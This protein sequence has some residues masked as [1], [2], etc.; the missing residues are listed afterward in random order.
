MIL[1][2]CLLKVLLRFG[3]ARRFTEDLSFAGA[4]DRKDFG[5]LGASRWPDNGDPRSTTRTR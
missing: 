1:P 2:P 3:K 4:I 5:R